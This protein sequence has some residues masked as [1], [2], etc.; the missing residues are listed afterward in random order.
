[1][2]QWSAP[3]PFFKPFFHDSLW[4]EKEDQILTNIEAKWWWIHSECVLLF[5]FLKTLCFST[6]HSCIKFLLFLYEMLQPHLKFC[7]TNA[8]QKGIQ[9][10]PDFAAFAMEDMMSSDYMNWFEKETSSDKNRYRKTKSNHKDKI[11]WYYWLLDS[12]IF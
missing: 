8:Q 2:P 7:S 4:K 10:E 6:T 9:S 12:I 3:P 1:M 5:S 11:K